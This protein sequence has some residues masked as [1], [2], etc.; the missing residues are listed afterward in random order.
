[1]IG[2]L[3]QHGKLGVTVIGNSREEAEDLHAH[4]LAILDREASYQREPPPAA[5]NSPE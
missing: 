2:A 5:L 1:M 4:A 3:S